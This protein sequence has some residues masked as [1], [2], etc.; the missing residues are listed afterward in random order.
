MPQRVLSWLFLPQFVILP[1]F[2][3]SQLV[4]LPDC[5]LSSPLSQ[6]KSKRVRVS[7]GKYKTWRRERCK[8]ST[9]C[10]PL[11]TSGPVSEKHKMFSVGRGLS[12]GPSC[13]HRTVHL[14]L[15]SREPLT[16][17]GTDGMFP[18]MPLCRLEQNML[19]MQSYLSNISVGR[20]NNSP[21]AL[22][23]I[24]IVHAKIF[25]CIHTSLY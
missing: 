17:M 8:S 20:S 2:T 21:L 5:M 24:P 12:R 18:Q 1:G 7:P 13:A 22:L 3:K 10:Q 19:V 11:P 14:P 16:A 25:D 9:T 4:C 23:S 6:D 15:C